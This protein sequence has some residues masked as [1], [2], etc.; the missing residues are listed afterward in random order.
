MSENNIIMK[1]IILPYILYFLLFLAVAGYWLLSYPK[2][3]L[4]LM[5]NEVHNGFL[6]ML[7]FIVSK[8]AEWPFYVIGI[9]PL[10]FWRAGWTYLYAMAEA[11]AA[12][13]I[14]VVKRF[15]DM[16]R[17]KICFA[18]HPELLKVVDGVRLH[19]HHSFPS[20]HTSSFF[21]FFT[22]L[23]LCL[24]LYYFRRERKGASIASRWLV[25]ALLLGMAV[26]GGYSRVYLS[27]HFL[28][29]VF[30]GSI[31][32]CAFATVS[33]LL[34]YKKGWMDTRWF[35]R[36]L[37]GKYRYGRSNKSKDSL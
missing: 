23:A 6:D 36:S 32:G 17:P 34:F 3:E 29:D 9:L 11:S 7:F 31:V 20:G 26:L 33:F 24:M 4:H 30:A 14:F 35:N 37:L 10:L 25:Y 19:G 8:F 2:L 5:M 22:V 16:P 27:Q 1:K 21:V 13:F 18:E 15:V 12:L 28:M